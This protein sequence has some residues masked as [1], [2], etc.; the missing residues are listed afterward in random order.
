MALKFSDLCRLAAD[1]CACT[2]TDIYAETL[3]LWLIKATGA[4]SLFLRGTGTVCLWLLMFLTLRS[5]VL[6]AW[7][8]GFA[9]GLIAIAYCLAYLVTLQSFFVVVRVI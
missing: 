5:S 1:A 2:Y 9:F 3:E 7:I 8:R 4:C 6:L